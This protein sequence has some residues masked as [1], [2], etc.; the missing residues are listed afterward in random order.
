MKKR[1]GEPH[2]PAPLCNACYQK[3]ARSLKKKD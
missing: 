3:E 1:E 2:A